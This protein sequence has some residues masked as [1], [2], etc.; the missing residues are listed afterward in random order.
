MLSPFSFCK[1]PVLHNLTAA[2]WPLHQ[3]KIVGL[4]LQQQLSMIIGTVQQE[5]NNFL[6]AALCLAQGHCCTSLISVPDE[7]QPSLQK[8]T[9]MHTGLVGATMDCQAGYNKYF[10]HCIL[11]IA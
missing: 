2:L 6:S 10:V 8:I 3:W 4:P 1:S 11:Y 9:D 5:F 7:Q